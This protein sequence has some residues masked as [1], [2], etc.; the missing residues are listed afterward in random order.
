MNSVMNMNLYSRGKY[1]K[2][3]VCIMTCK[4]DQMATPDAF[5]TH[6]DR[7]INMFERNKNYP[8]LTLV[9]G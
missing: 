1:Q 4:E 9:I 8:S 2:A 6:M 5:K 7:T 3:T